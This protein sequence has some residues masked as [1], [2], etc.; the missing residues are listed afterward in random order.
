MAKANRKPP[1]ISPRSRQNQLGPEKC[2]GVSGHIFTESKSGCSIANVNLIDSPGLPDGAAAQPL[3]I[4]L[5]GRR[6][7][8]YTTFFAASVIFSPP[9]FFFPRAILFLYYFFTPNPPPKKN[10]QL[11]E[12]SGAFEIVMSLLKLFSQNFYSR[13]GDGGAHL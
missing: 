8:V 6:C 5:K 10:H 9:V 1:A 7:V 13:L 12:F 3:Q 11:W 4:W 2:Q